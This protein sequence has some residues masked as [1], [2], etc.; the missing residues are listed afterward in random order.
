MRLAATGLVLCL[1][2]LLACNQSLASETR[3]DPN[4]QTEISNTE[5]AP[6][7]LINT[8]GE[9]VE[10]NL[11]LANIHSFIQRAA[12][13]EIL[14]SAE[15][16]KQLEDGATLFQFNA[17]AECRLAAAQ[18]ESGYLNLDHNMQIATPSKAL[19]VNWSFYCAKPEALQEVTIALFTHF[20]QGFEQ[21]A[22]EWVSEFTEGNVET[23]TDTLIRLK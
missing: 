22:I 2:L 6:R 1:N 23:S 19:H 17:S 11:E 9:S 12:L 5:A 14:G 16:K 4:L 20:P 3:F 8:T 13:L 15:L 21:L 10:L 7:L 18:A